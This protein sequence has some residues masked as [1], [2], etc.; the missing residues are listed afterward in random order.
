MDTLSLEGVTS[1]GADVFQNQHISPHISLQLKK[2]LRKN[3]R[4]NLL[5]NSP[6][7]NPVDISPENW[8]NSTFKFTYPKHRRYFPR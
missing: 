7:Q 6:T 4:L 3:T 8:K 2:T 5:L 1:F